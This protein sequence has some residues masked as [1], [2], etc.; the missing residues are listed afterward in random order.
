M[1]QHRVGNEKSDELQLL[2]KKQLIKKR[3][4]EIKRLERL[5]TLDYENKKTSTII[6]TK[7]PTKTVYFA[8][9]YISNR[10]KEK[11]FNN[12]LT[13]NPQNKLKEESN[14][15]TNYYEST[16]PTGQNEPEI[17]SY[18][19]TTKNFNKTHYENLYLKQKTY[20]KEN[21]NNNLQIK[22]SFNKKFP[23]KKS[24]SLNPEKVTN[25]LNKFSNVRNVNN[26]N[27]TYTNT[28]KLFLNSKKANKEFS[29]NSFKPKMSLKSANP[30]EIPDEDKI[31]DE[32]NEINDSDKKKFYNTQQNFLKLNLQ[33]KIPIK[34]YKLYESKNAKILN[35]LYKF[36]KEYKK[37]VYN[38][39]HKK[40]ELE[41]DNY[42]KNIINNIS[43][44]ISKNL[45]KRLQN[46]FIDLYEYA[47]SE[48]GDDSNKK[49]IIETE[50]KEKEIIHEINNNTEEITQRIRTAA[51]DS[52]SYQLNSELKNFYL[53]KVKFYRTV[54]VKKKNFCNVLFK[55]INFMKMKNNQQ[56]EKD[57]QSLNKII[58]KYKK[59]KFYMT[60]NN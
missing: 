52:S 45:V 40:N 12:N 29:L 47:Y 55:G 7:K 15:N 44:N 3:T 58:N 50:D 42:Q 32:M 28:D 9:G 35:D 8:D 16:E 60:Q 26:R 39:I 13:F 27:A 59:S 49:F 51:N 22:T 37:K 38:A 10:M 18:V 6:H 4:I 24:G 19:K 46:K 31:F 17:T 11:I 54:R 53:P 43:D 2:L 21:E 57:N 5:Y 14:Y 1:L 48:Y 30:L 25:F 34:K 20:V 41:L 36:S 33:Q 23:I 56:E